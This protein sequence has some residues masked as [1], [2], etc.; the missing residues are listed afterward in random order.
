MRAA[1][2]C[3]SGGESSLRPPEQLVQTPPPDCL[4]QFACTVHSDCP[5]QSEGP[6][7]FF[8]VTAAS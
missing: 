8:L 4:N 3:D 5:R 2:R 1:W 6:W 7:T